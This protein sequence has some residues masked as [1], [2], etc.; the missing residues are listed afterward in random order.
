MKMKPG[1]AQILDR[2]RAYITPGDTVTEEGIS[3]KGGGYFCFWRGDLT[4]AEE[5]RVFRHFVKVAI[6][7]VVG[8]GSDSAVAIANQWIKWLNS[9]TN[10]NR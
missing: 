2:N 9:R 8:Y 10:N 5:E 7:Y 4:E 1:T 3:V 6:G